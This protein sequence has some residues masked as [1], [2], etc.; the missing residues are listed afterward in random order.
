MT[1]NKTMLSL[2]KTLLLSCLLLPPTAVG[3]ARQVS[4]PAP[5]TASP[6]EQCNQCGQARDG[7]YDGIVTLYHDQGQIALKLLGFDKGVTIH[8]GLPVPI[9]TPAHGT[10]FDI[11]G[12]NKANVDATR[13]SISNRLPHGRTLRGQDFLPR[14]TTLPRAR[15]GDLRLGGARGRC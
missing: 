1:R 3:W 5:G 8:G 15:S 13:A 6:G 9:T 11:P 14:G 4:L 10:A 2:V 7:Q 12:Q